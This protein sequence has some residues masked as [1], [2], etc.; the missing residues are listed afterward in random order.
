METGIFENKRPLYQ[1]VAE[2]LIAGIENGSYAVGEL[3]P[4]EAQ[5]CNKYSVSRHT[6]RAAIRELTDRRMLS[7]HP[8]VG[9]RIISQ[10]VD[11]Y[12]QTL[13]DISDLTG[14]VMDTSRKTLK[15]ERVVAADAGI[16]MPGEP[17]MEWQMF[18]AIRQVIGSGKVIAWTRVFVLPQYENSLD[19]VPEN[20]LVYTMIEERSNI[21]TAKLRQVI[22]A[23][24]CPEEPAKWLEIEV[25]S[26]A[27][28]V[29]REY[30][31]DQREVFEVSWSIHPPDRFEN[32]MELELSQ[33]RA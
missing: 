25:G 18:E 24:A 23:I 8:G 5:L 1:V 2:Q 19:E 16:P 33:S 21:K 10:R 9:T 22:K 11:N 12:S 29:I 4:S 20:G 27:L 32:K 26:P 7:A 15:R 31:S 13:K 14:Y 3:L 28:S 30:M 17:D 6:V